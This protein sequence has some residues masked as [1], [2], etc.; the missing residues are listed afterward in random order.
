MRLPRTVW[1]RI[2]HDVEGIRSLGLTVPA[3]GYSMSPC[4]TS[5]EKTTMPDRR[6][7]ARGLPAIPAVGCA[8]I[9]H[10]RTPASGRWRVRRWSGCG[11]DG[12]RDTGYRDGAAGPVGG[13][14]DRGDCAGGGVCDV[15][16]L[17]VGRDGESDR[18]AACGDERAG[19]ARAGGD[20][21]DGAVPDAVD[22]ALAQD[23]GFLAVRGDD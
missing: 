10:S 12:V 9:S 17:A 7:F 8:Q 15:E 23:V 3:D 21:R 13:G 5:S 18:V 16:R 6:I 14:A 2:W 1:A 11:E 4:R 22:L 20:R 19:L